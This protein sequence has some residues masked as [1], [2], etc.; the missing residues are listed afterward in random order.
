[1]KNN[2]YITVLFLLIIIALSTTIL[3]LSQDIQFNFAPIK[4]WEPTEEPNTYILSG[5]HN[6][7]KDAH[8]WIFLRDR[9]R[10][11]YLQ[12]PSVEII[13]ENTWEAPNVVINENI[14]YVWAIL[15][16]T[17]GNRKLTKIAEQMEIQQDWHA[18]K[19]EM[20]EALSGYQKLANITIKNKLPQMSAQKEPEQKTKKPPIQTQ[21][22][23]ELKKKS[24]IEN[25][26]FLIADFEEGKNEG[27]LHSWNHPKKLKIEAEY[28]KL[29]SPYM[30]NSNYA[31]SV[32]LP[33]SENVTQDGWSGG[34]LVVLF[35]ENGA[36]MDISDYKYI[37]FDICATQES[38]L[39]NTYIKLEASEG[40]PWAERPLSL[41]GINL[42]SQW[43]TAKIPLQDFTKLK[44]TDPE[45][46]KKLNLKAITKLV[47]VSILN[48][49]YNTKGTL[50]IDNIYLTK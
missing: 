5:S 2:S 33:L 29:T 47:T 37:Q 24:D 6:L 39:Q 40:G 42:S 38:N 23:S 16:D 31:A 11:L 25:I 32:T 1:M 12:Y 27:R 49:K 3:G 44:A 22:P 4:D 8:V 43:Q 18:M 19:Q 35:K 21:K 48:E 9:Y 41:Y 10:N 26:S 17:T 28:K 34:G 50:F 15:V 7:S 30:N 14:R 36:G 46:W 45:N 13:D 20:V